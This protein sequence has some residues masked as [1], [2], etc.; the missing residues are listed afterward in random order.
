MVDLSHAITVVV[1][2]LIFAGSI[3]AVLI[4]TG[5]IVRY[6]SDKSKSEWIPSLASW[7]GM[8]FALLC[9]TLTPVDIYATSLTESLIQSKSPIF[10]NIKLLYMVLYGVVTAFAFVVL[11]FV[12]FYYEAADLDKSTGRQCFDGLKFSIGFFI[13]LVICIFVGLFVSTGGSN[14]GDNADFRQWVNTLFD[15]TNRGER[16]VLFCLGCLTTL[17][18]VIWITYSAFGMSALPIGLIKGRKSVTDEKDDVQREMNRNLVNASLL[19]D[20]ELGQ[21]RMGR[22]RDVLKARTARLEAKAGAC[23]TKCSRCMRPFSIL[24]GILFGLISLFLAVCIILGAVEQILSNYCGAQCGFIL[25]EPR[26]KNPIDQLLVILHRVFP[27]DFALVG[28]IVLYFFFCTIKGLKRIQ[29]R[30]F[31]MK[32]YNYSRNHTPPQGLILGTFLV[33]L[34]ILAMNVQLL[35]LAPQYAYWGGRTFHNATED[36]TYPCSIEYAYSDEITQGGC[37]M[38]QIGRIFT[39]LKW[40]FSYFGAAFYFISWGFILTFIIGIFVSVCSSADSNIEHY[41]DDDESSYLT[42]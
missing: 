24:F 30:C 6:F 33:M 22:D 32:L 34:A 35:S 2:W 37:Q 31:C 29:I 25:K 8:T 17:G 3:L 38:T 26:I 42:N 1:P 21:A 5:I 10:G 12:Y 14:G 7:L 28:F 36:K 13:I 39:T 15:T 27:L 4:L 41:S 11:P 23:A 9:I 20:D 40:N 19:E 18:M 16:A